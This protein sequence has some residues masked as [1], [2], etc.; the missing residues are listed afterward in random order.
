M[1][2]YK[3]ATALGG[4]YD[5]IPVHAMAQ[6]GTGLDYEVELVAVI[7]KKC[8]DVSEAKALDYVL[9]YAVGNDVSHRDWQIKWGGSQWS[10][11]KGFDGWAPWGPGIVSSSLIKDPQALKVKTVLN[12]K[13][14]Q[15]SIPGFAAFRIHITRYLS[16]LT[17]VTGLEHI[18]YDL[19][20]RPD[21]R[22]S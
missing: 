12:G 14:M 9:G 5:P 8:A 21:H 18:G 17:L 22:I 16:G 1:L 3:P 7:G 10:L 4:P 13:T 6:E 19:P 20:S 15:V 11:G 2:F